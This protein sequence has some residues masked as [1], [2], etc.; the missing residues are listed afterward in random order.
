MQNRLY[1]DHA[2][3]YYLLLSKWERGQLSIPIPKPLT[4]HPRL[5]LSGVAPMIPQIS[6]QKTECTPSGPP[7]VPLEGVLNSGGGRE[8]ERDLEETEEL[9]K[10]PNLHRYLKHGR[11]HTLGAA[12]NTKFA[13]DM[14]RYVA[15]IVLSPLN[16]LWG[17]RYTRLIIIFY[18]TL[19]SRF[20]EMT[21]TSNNQLSNGFGSCNGGDNPADPGGVGGAAVAWHTI[22]TSGV[23]GSSKIQPNLDHS[24][25]NSVGGPMR[26]LHQQFQP[27]TH[28]NLPIPK[29]PRMGRRV[30]DGGPY[31]DAYRL[32]IEKR[33]PQL[34][35][36]KS[37]TNI[38][39][40]DSTNMS[41][42]NSVK[43]LLQETQ[44]KKGY[45][46]LPNSRREWLQFKNEVH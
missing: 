9:I 12:H 7:L 21:E 17:K 27:Q 45:G 4:P 40:C 46:G 26:H 42:T 6:I 1:N 30:S 18:S 36:I 10:D 5:S 11:R 25:Q 28:Q 16:T 20:L 29:N 2:A 3:L 31:A 33:Y 34:P 35:Q 44:E 37:S 19:C 15:N 8:D 41:S 13:E 43:M 14:K 32:Y 22:P 24:S 23:M 38:E 39:R